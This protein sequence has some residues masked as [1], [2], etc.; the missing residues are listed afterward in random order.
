MSLEPGAEDHIAEDF[1]IHR[2]E[3]R[4]RA[5]SHVRF[6]LSTSDNRNSKSFRHIANLYDSV[7]GMVFAQDVK[8][9]NTF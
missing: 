6:D 5:G 8:F 3:N 9:S 2:D 1:S 7:A 4:E